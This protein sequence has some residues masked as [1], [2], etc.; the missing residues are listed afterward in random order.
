VRNYS[1]PRSI[2][3]GYR[4]NHKHLHRR[5]PYCAHGPFVFPSASF[6]GFGE[7]LWSNFGFSNAENVLEKR[8]IAAMASIVG[9]LM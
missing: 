5:W 4:F 9:G 3:C 7:Q 2:F 8:C 6:A 1:L